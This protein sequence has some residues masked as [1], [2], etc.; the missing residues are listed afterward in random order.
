LPFFAIS[1]SWWQSFQD[2]PMDLLRKVGWQLTS[3]GDNQ[4]K[5]LQDITMASLSF[6]E[7]VV[8]DGFSMF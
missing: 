3:F 6:F 4:A 2:N 1:A 5:A 8:L 7:G